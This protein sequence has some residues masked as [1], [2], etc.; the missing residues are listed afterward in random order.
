MYEGEDTS[1][2]LKLPVIPKKY[3]FIHTHTHIFLSN[4]VVEVALEQIFTI[5]YQRMVQHSVLTNS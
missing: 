1:V 3:G 4:F 5:F 2:K